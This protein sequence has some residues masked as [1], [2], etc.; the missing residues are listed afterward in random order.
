MADNEGME[1]NEEAFISAQKQIQLSVTALIARDIWNM[2]EYFE[3]MTDVTSYR[4][5]MS[6]SV[7]KGKARH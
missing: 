4:A 7:I 5:A 1:R 6:G 2:S 3:I